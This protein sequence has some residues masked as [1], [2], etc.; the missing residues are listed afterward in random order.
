MKVVCG[1]CAVAGDVGCMTVGTCIPFA[2]VLLKCGGI[3]DEL[4]LRVNLL[5]LGS[6]AQ[7]IGG[8]H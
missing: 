7:I 8:S 4:P 5:E 2:A 6:F 1:G 3:A